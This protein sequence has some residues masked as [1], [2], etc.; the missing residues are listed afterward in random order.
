[1]VGGCKCIKTAKRAKIEYASEEGGIKAA[2]DT[3]TKSFA[4]ANSASIESANNRPGLE[5]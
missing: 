5:S 3:F 1:M 4:D 2:L